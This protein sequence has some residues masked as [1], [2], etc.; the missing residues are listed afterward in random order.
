MLQIGLLR[1]V[2]VS[3]VF[4]A[5][6]GPTVFEMF[7]LTSSLIWICS[8]AAVFPDFDADL[9]QI[10]DVFHETGNPHIN[11]LSLLYTFY[12]EVLL[13]ISKFIIKYIN[14]FRYNIDYNGL[15]QY[16]YIQPGVLC[17]CFVLEDIKII[18]WSLF[19]FG[20]L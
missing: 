16:F 10:S 12:I 7:I 4:S 2:S 11:M 9:G 15:A 14:Y 17:I 3:S 18:F 6:R 20:T 1:A 13:L 8:C 5:I 19:F